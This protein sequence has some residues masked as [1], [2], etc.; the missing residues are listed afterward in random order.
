[1]PERTCSAIRAEVKK[2]SAHTTNTKGGNPFIAGIILGSTKYQR[3]TWTSRGI[4]RNNST[5]A[6]P[7][8]TSQG[9]SGKVRATPTSDPSTMAMSNPPN[10]TASVQPQACTIQCR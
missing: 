10:D 4:L 2:P 5:Q 1:M 7:K 6:L 3:N 9:L 8:R